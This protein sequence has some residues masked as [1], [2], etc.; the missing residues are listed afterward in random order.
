[1]AMV[2]AF[3]DAEIGDT[4]LLVLIDARG[5][6]RGCGREN[7]EML[8]VIKFTLLRGIFGNI[9]CV[10]TSLTLPVLLFLKFRP[11]HHASASPIEL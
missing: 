3:G 10:R 4:P 8:S 1:M 9:S 11:K 7:A 6:R 5:G 2:R